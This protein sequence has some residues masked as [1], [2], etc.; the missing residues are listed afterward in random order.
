MEVS[1]STLLSKARG[2]LTATQVRSYMLRHKAKFAFRM[3]PHGK[4]DHLKVQIQGAWYEIEPF[5]SY[6]SQG[7]VQDFKLKLLPMRDSE[8]PMELQGV[9][10]IREWNNAWAGNLGQY[11]MF[12]AKYLSKKRVGNK[13]VY[14]YKD[15]PKKK[16]PRKERSVPTKLHPKLIQLIQGSTLGEFLTFVSEH[17]GSM[18]DATVSDILGHISAASEGGID[19]KRIRKQLMEGG[20][21][22]FLYK[23]SPTDLDIEEAETVDYEGYDYEKPIV[24][25]KDGYVIDGR[26]R[27]LAAISE[28]A[29]E[30]PAYISAKELYRQ[31]KGLQKAKPRKYISRKRVG[32]KWV[33]KYK[34]D[35]DGQKQKKQ[36]IWAGLSAH[37]GLDEGSVKNI[38]LQAYSALKV[39]EKLDM[40]KQSWVNHMF[41][42]FNNKDGWDKALSTGKNPGGKWNSKAMQFLYGFYGTK[43]AKEKQQAVN[44]LP[45][46]KKETVLSK[47][48]M[49][50]FG[51]WMHNPGDSS[52]VV[53][54]NGIPEE[55]RPIKVYHGTAR[56]GF[57]AFSKKKSQGGIY[58]KGF[59]FTEDEGIATEY[60]KKDTDDE[61]NK[62][63]MVTKLIDARTGKEIKF[64]QAFLQAVW[65]SDVKG[66][67][68]K[69]AV[70]E[71]PTPT[72]GHLSSNPNY[73]EYF[74]K[75]IENSAGKEYT[76]EE[77]VETYDNTEVESYGGRMASPSSG[78][79]GTGKSALLNTVIRHLEEQ[80]VEL[81]LEEYPPQVYEVYLN[82]KNPCDMDSIIT[83]EQFKQFQDIAGDKGLYMD[84]I[85]E[86]DFWKETLGKDYALNFNE[87]TMD[88]FVKI[89]D[90]MRNLI[91]EEDYTDWTGR[92]YK[93]GDPVFPVMHLSTSDKL[94][95]GELQY[96]MTN[97]QQFNNAATFTEDIKGMGFD[98]IKHT[99]GYNIGTKNHTVWIGFEPNQIKSTEAQDFD[100]KDDNIYKAQGKKY[101]SRKRVGGKWV[102][103]YRQD[104]PRPAAGGP[105]APRA[106]VAEK[107]KIRK[108]FRKKIDRLQ[109]LLLTG[110]MA[111]AATAF[112]AILKFVQEYKLTLLLRAQ[113][114]SDLA[115]AE[116][117]LLKA[118]RKKIKIRRKNNV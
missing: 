48:F 103:K 70:G 88:D 33:Y 65:D 35:D 58:G 87:Y 106:S 15:D 75:M 17:K 5:Y 52:K 28:G 38:P 61:Y 42:Y 109:T 108:Q 39:K 104:K 51:D 40:D 4:K 82:I 94:T 14:K 90:Y 18:G 113:D 26:H 11:S 32:N 31:V 60:T 115:Q 66:L 30:M 34:D 71:N 76:T 73:N 1:L 84:D 78:S 59:Y 116:K 2:D 105:A 27:S 93:A 23:V 117:K 21:T 111:Q 54:K 86:Y 50:W 45:A 8:I 98:G 80:G 85:S 101:I 74:E 91:R 107:K 22:Y 110:K 56:G 102:Y 47:S 24:V 63:A 83:Q 96:I 69:K 36:S 95:W 118:N 81:K 9:F 79:R 29:T 67:E 92:E 46:K 25:G 43:K 20:E 114:L 3:K 12:K 55:Q 112:T 44:S 53:D 97:A 7:K 16:F 19:L 100:A 6:S 49:S 13:W 41:Q 89:R 68:E 77:L 72:T 37:F 62:R 57:Q 99:G 64:D 10:T